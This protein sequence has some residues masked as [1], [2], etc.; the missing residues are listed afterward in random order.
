M[1][2][3]RRVLL[4]APRG[5][6][7]G[8]DRA[9]LVVDEALKLYGPPVYVR[10]QIVHNKFV[11]QSLESRGA[12]FVDEIEQI[13][14]GS[15]AVFSA[16]GVSPAVRSEAQDRGLRTIDATCPLVTKVHQEA[17]RFAAEGYRIMLIGHDGHEEVEGTAG[18]APEATTLVQSPQDAAAI[19]V[20]P[21]EKVAWL[22]QTTLSVDETLE[23]VD[24]LRRSIP[25]L[26]NPPSD[27]ICYATQNRQAAVKL[28]APRCDVVIVVGSSNSSN[29]LRLVDV[30]LD[31]GARR[32]LP[33]RRR[34]RDRPGVAGRGLDRRRHLRRVGARGPGRRGAGAP[35]GPRASG[36]WRSWRPWRSG[37]ASRCRPTCAARCAS[38]SSS[39]P[40]PPHPETARTG[41]SSVRSMGATVVDRELVSSWRISGMGSPTTSIDSSRR[42]ETSTRVS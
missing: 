1:T 11:V 34:G 41:G 32:G 14:V 3:P 24:E 4:A 19:T 35:A 9:I 20:Q 42:A 31:S 22:S 30:A 18:E 5:F 26:V 15:V 23:T 6:C 8:V 13:P 38:G 40:D 2:D 7:A 36:T 10:K 29:S 21:G 16:H 27:D 39:R 12:I 17:R 25:L 28:M 37:C 33:D